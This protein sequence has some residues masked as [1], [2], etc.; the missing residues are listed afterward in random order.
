MGVCIDMYI[1]W[2]EKKEIDVMHKVVNALMRNGSCY[3]GNQTWNDEW[4]QASSVTSHSNQVTRLPVFI[5]DISRLVRF[6]F[7]C[8]HSVSGRTTKHEVMS[9][10]VEICKSN[11]NRTFFSEAYEDKEMSLCQYFQK[12]SPIAGMMEWTF[13]GKLRKQQFLKQQATS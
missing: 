11:R 12:R 9:A 4:D 3:H 7:I 13:F 8:Q 5:C 2:G 1:Y 6:S 10:Q